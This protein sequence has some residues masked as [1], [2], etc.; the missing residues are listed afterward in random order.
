M[1]TKQIFIVRINDLANQTNISGNGTREIES[2]S[3][4]GEENGEHNGVGSVEVSRIFMPQDTFVLER[5]TLTE[6]RQINTTAD[7]VI[8][9]SP[10]L[11]VLFYKVL[12]ILQT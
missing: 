7:R 8:W 2:G 3:H 10:D 9:L 11:E 12:C 6:Y 5:Y 1:F 4:N